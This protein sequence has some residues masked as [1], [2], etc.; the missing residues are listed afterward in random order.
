MDFSALTKKLRI[1]NQT[2]EEML[3]TK[4][5]TGGQPLR[6]KKLTKSYPELEDDVYTLI[7]IL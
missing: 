1:T 6:W 7:Q 5:T 3:A 4:K 2:E